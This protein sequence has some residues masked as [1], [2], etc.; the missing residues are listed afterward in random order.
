MT[1]QH[2]TPEFVTLQRAVAGRFTLVRELGRGGMGVVFL[3]RD[4]ALDRLVAIKLLPPA[5]AVDDTQ[6]DRFLREARIAAGLSHP[7]IVPIHTVEEQDGLVWF[8]M[9]FVDG[10]TLGE[11]VRRSGP[12]TGAEA[13]RITQEVAWALAHAHGRGIV[14]RDMKPDNILL[15]RGTDRALV[16]DFG[17]A[18]PVAGGA[19][20][21]GTPH[22]LSPE[23]ARGES[24]EARS[25][26]YALGVTAWFALTGRLPF[27]GTTPALLVQHAAAPVPALLSVLPP[28]H[29]VP[30]R[31]VRLIERT[32]AKSP[33]DRP[34]DAA[35]L[36]AEIDVAR[37]GTVA[38][39][40]AIRAFVRDAESAG[41]E[42]GTALVAS[43]TS[44]LV[45]Y[46]LFPDDLFAVSVFITAS[47][48]TAGLAL[49][50]FGQV[51]LHARRLLADGYDFGAVRSEILRE[52]ATRREVGRGSRAKLRWATAAMI[53]WTAVKTTAL[54][55]LT[56]LDG[57]LWLSLVG[58]AGL[59]VVPAMAIRMVWEDLS[60]G[61]S[62]WNRMLAGRLGRRLFAG[63]ALFLR[64]ARAS[65][66]DTST[67]TVVAL[68]D[69]AREA[70]DA[71]PAAER[72][73]LAEVPRLL[74][75]MRAH[76]RAL[77]D[78]DDP[79][80]RERLGSVAAALEML[81]LDL[82]RAAA[83]EGVVPQI[84]A[85]LAA[86]RAISDRVDEALDAKRGGATPSPRPET[87][88]I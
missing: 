34:G 5:L 52:E 9:T 32:M 84:T 57:P 3:A 42:M 29:R 46:S 53:A 60:A 72:A 37:L 31:F 65:A 33:S 69:T 24:P 11:R 50:R 51:V 12:L 66:T 80:A 81:R 18:A 63:A 45:L 62:L 1:Q 4:V 67:P 20:A 28:H 22:Y 85:D 55:F 47:F 86:A 73:Q 2:V 74:D 26:L 68:S 21:G 82:L 56:Q 59:V 48:L 19:P 54:A 30:P 7:H 79:V 15:E 87:T 71:L 13:M 64:R 39:A 8:A 43:A 14:H 76:A 38:A 77:H 35:T 23:Q 41:G 40:P 6:R 83:G 75:R 17:I 36:A 58:A 16:A 10:E 25:D 78:R 61:R 70:F 88:P 49:I 44:I 27:E